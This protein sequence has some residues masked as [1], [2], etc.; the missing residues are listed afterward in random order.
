MV[1][2]PL[3][4]LEES[5]N[6][7]LSSKSAFFRRFFFL[8]AFLP[9]LSR[10]HNLREAYELAIRTLDVLPPAHAASKTV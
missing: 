4:E 8:V 7:P 10:S 1:Q 5:W 9:P 2:R 3:S 6:P